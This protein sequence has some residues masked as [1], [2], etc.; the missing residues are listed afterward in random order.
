MRKVHGRYVIACLPVSSGVKLVVSILL[1]IAATMLVMAG[2]ALAQTPS[3][4]IVA[5]SNP[6]LT[7]GQTQQFEATS[8]GGLTF[9]LG[10][11]TAITAGDKH[12]CALLA[13][14]T[15]QCWGSNSAGQVG[16]GGLAE[17]AVPVA[18]NGLTGVTA[19]AAGTSHTC[20]LLVDGTARC[21][22]FNY[23][24]ELGNG[25]TLTSLPP[26]GTNTPVEV[27]ALSTATALAAGDYHTCALLIDGAVQCWGRNDQG[28]LGS[29]NTQSSSS[30]V[31]VAGLTGAIAIAAGHAHT[32][33][34]L[35]AGGVEC[36]GENAGG[37]LGNGTNANSSTPVTVTGLT[38]AIALAAGYEHTCALLANGKVACWGLNNDG[39]LGNGGNAATNQPLLSNAGGVTAIT[40]RAEETCARLSNGTAQ[41]WGQNSYGELGN[42]SKVASAIPVAVSSLDGV[43]KLAVGN[44]HACALLSDGSV[45]CWGDNED[46]ELGND[47]TSDSTSDSTAPLVVTAGA[48]LPAAGVTQL[49][50]GSDSYNCVLVSDG[51][52]QCIGLWESNGSTSTLTTVPGISGVA[53]LD[54]NYQFTCVLLA[55]GTMECWGEDA[56][57]EIGNGFVPPNSPFEVYVPPAAVAGVSSAKS[58]SVGYH[59]A[60]A[61]MDD[62][63]VQCWG[64]NYDGELG[65]GTTTTTAPYG[66]P[67]PVT[68]TGLT[69]AKAVSVGDYFSCALLADG[70][71]KC[72]G[73]NGDGQLG[74]GTT[75]AATTPVA[76]QGVTGARAIAASLSSACAVLSNGTLQCWGDPLTL[77][78]SP[79]EVKA[80][81]AGL[82]QDCVLLVNGTAECWGD[83]HYGELGNGSFTN[84]DTPVLV[85]GVGLD[86]VVANDERSCA[87]LADGLMECWGNVS[88]LGADYPSLYS[89]TPVMAPPLASAVTWSSGNPSVAV[90]DPVTGIVTAVAS[91]QT[92]IA[93]QYGSLNA[94]TTLTVLPPAQI[95]PA[96]TWPAP[97]PIPYGFLLGSAQLN[98]TASVPGTFVYTPPA[99]ALLSPGVQT[100]SVVFTPT[101]SVDYSSASAQVTITVVVPSLTATPATLQLNFNPQLVGTSSVA[102]YIVLRNTAAAPVAVGPATVTGPFVISNQSGTCITSMTLSWERSCVIRVVFAPAAPGPAS[103]QV[104]ISSPGTVGGAY[105]VSLSGTGQGETAALT[106]STTSV[107]FPT[108]QALGTS[109]G[110][111]YVQIDSTGTAS[112]VV[113]GVTLGGAD[114]GDFLVSNQAGTCTTGATLVYNAKCNLRIVFSPKGSGTRTA[115][116]FIADNAAGSPQQVLLSGTGQ[117][118][119]PLTVTPASLALTYAATP[120]G[121]ETVAQYITLKN[122]GSSPVI[123]SGAALGGSDPGDFLLSNQAGPCTTGQTLAPGALC[124]LRVNFKPTAAG[125]RSAMVTVTDNST[126]GQYVVN[127]T[128][129]GK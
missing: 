28:Q 14:S 127:L 53:S 90:I 25:L 107:T 106:L 102:Q 44:G 117:G 64:F 120:V 89:D 101:D 85:S 73:V 56:Y 10:Q 88:L 93:A 29:G 26:Y 30:P 31:A 20:A 22:G 115:T 51:A 69:S 46:G 55:G 34:L 86:A 95:T 50:L 84:S 57:G 39:E 94:S 103:G 119:A 59:D 58:I 8:G 110:A 32:C 19:L 83:N 4:I 118:P 108:P 116:L 112:L 104:V 68:V 77:V 71:V 81:A 36:W 37:Q 72:W 11:A 3:S 96:I 62:G 12:T 61:V 129:T 75:N 113:S 5:P 111:R 54:A 70:T 41:C 122:A 13:D 24:G 87:V 18:V 33:A 23:D 45:N 6:V 92:T 27:S 91:G 40:A 9:P 48:A 47:S 121:S 67:T 99:G 80:M 17:S 63:T 15:V 2:T 78:N 7:A 109:S 21:W 79:P 105:T 35:D 1:C 74:D 65:N 66:S 124:N 100:L 76:V 43:I 42:G 60:C 52:V 82:D 126:A 38:G 97:A 98:A 114:P 16:A 123:V 128:G 125:A 49:V